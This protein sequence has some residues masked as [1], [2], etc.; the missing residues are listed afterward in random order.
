MSVHIASDWV[1]RMKAACSAGAGRRGEGIRQRPAACGATE[2]AEGALTEALGRDEGFEVADDLDLQVLRHGDGVLVVGQLADDALDD[3]RARQDG[4]GAVDAAQASE[5]D[6]G[7][8]N[9][10]EVRVCHV[11]ADRRADGDDA[12]RGVREPA[13]SLR[14]AVDVL[15][16]Q[17]LGR[18]QDVGCGRGDEQQRQPLHF[19]LGEKGRKAEET[20]PARQTRP[21]HRRSRATCASTAGGEET[22][23][24][25]SVESRTGVE[26]MAEL[27]ACR[28]RTDMVE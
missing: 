12:E 19:Q 23:R 2:L 14:A 3:V 10:L 26:H 22:A 20:Y 4:G 6:V 21:G 25:V 5:Q 27:T 8:V 9:L 28:V 11:V 18:D 24:A 7:A 17:L 15:R 16:Q 1:A 13:V